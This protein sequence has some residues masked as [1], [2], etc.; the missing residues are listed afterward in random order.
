[1]CA[2]LSRELC[3]FGDRLERSEREA[4]YWS[5]LCIVD[6]SKPI[7]P[8]FHRAWVDQGDLFVSQNQTFV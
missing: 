8:A 4:Q 7:A 5:R 2:G 3:D 1:L 6:Q